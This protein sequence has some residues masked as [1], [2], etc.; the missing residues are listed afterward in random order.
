[1]L[2]NIF[3]FYRGL[4]VLVTLNSIKHYHPTKKTIDILDKHYK[5]ID[6]NS[7]IK[8]KDILY[9]CGFGE[10]LWISRA[11]ENNSKKM[12]SF[13]LKCL[14]KVAHLYKDPVTRKAYEVALA[15]N[16][17][18]AT[19]HDIIVQHN[20]MFN[21]CNRVYW[22]AAG[23]LL[24]TLGPMPESAWCVS[25]AVASE[26]GGGIMQ[27]EKYNEVKKEQEVIFREILEN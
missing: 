11:S 2:N 12:F 17:D 13:S 16:E 7:P 24:W 4:I 23:A 6:P 18:R 3:S 5:D 15:Y 27:N 8:I 19:E 14:D 1:M 22:S 21:F 25:T 26:I 9:K 20:E 10:A